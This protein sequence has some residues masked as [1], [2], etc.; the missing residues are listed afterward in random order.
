MSYID[1]AIIAPS[2]RNSLHRVG[3]R[4]GRL[5]RSARGSLARLAKSRMRNSGNVG[6]SRSDRCG[7]AHVAHF[8]QRLAAG[9]TGA[10]TPFAYAYGAELVGFSHARVH[11]N[12]LSAGVKSSRVLYTYNIARQS[13]NPISVRLKFD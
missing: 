12:H 13:F 11:G 5:H 4:D 7:N 9:K 6:V 10:Q 1:I 8:G 2:A 3:P